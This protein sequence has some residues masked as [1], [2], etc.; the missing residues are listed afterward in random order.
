M[1]SGRLKRLKAETA[2]VVRRWVDT[3]YYDS[4]EKNATAQWNTLILP[5]LE[6]DAIDFSHVLELAMGHGRMT[7]LLLEKAVQVT[8][9]DV[10]QENV[11]FCANRFSG[12]ARP[13]TVAE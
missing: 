2:Q 7:A 11:D 1:D 12:C 8:A 3:P 13:Q 4:V 9:V 5:F 10:L 6:G